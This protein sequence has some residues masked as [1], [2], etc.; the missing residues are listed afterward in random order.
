MRPDMS[1]KDERPLS[2]RRAGQSEREQVLAVINRPWS[3]GDYFDE[4]LQQEIESYRHEAEDRPQ[5][6]AR[7]NGD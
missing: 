2:E 4:V 6:Q 1:G 3:A 7:Y 5:A